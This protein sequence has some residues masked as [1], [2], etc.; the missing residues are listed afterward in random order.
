MEC[1]P[2]DQPEAMNDREKWKERGSGISM[3]AAGHD[4][5]DDDDDDDLILFVCSFLDEHLSIII[6]NI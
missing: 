5:G 3:Q 1:I 2:E 4:D 6:I